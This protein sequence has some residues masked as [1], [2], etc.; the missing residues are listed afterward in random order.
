MSSDKEETGEIY[1]L[2][3]P[4]VMRNLKKNLEIAKEKGSVSW[5]DLESVI[6]DKLKEQGKLGYQRIK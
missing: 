2:N 1:G 3:D 6:D 5:T 4:L